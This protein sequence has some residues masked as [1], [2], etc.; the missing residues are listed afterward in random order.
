VSG[1]ILEKGKRDK[2]EENDCGDDCHHAVNHRVV[3]E[4]LESFHVVTS[5]GFEDLEQY[6]IKLPYPF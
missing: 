4:L 2:S 1:W 5:T 3:G 6:S